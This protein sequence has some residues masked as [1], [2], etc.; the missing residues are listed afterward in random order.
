MSQ[1]NIKLQVTLSP[2]VYK[3]LT[4]WAK[5]HGESP[6]S[7]ARIIISQQCQDNLEKILER[8]KMREE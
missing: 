5:W 3:V 6:S 4:M 1:E 8:D 7:F 2:E